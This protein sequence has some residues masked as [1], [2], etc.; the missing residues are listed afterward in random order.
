MSTYER[1]I[2]PYKEE[3]DIVI[4]NNDELGGGFIVFEG[5]LRQQ[6]QQYKTSTQ[7]E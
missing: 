7:Q 5:F 1:Y 2:E 6:L 4:N 3:V